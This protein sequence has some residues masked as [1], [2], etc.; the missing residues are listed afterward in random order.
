MG[1][2]APTP[3]DHQA[4][5]MAANLYVFA[6]SA[7]FGVPI[8]AFP[9]ELVHATGEAAG[10]VLAKYAGDTSPEL[11]LAMAAGSLA[12][13]AWSYDPDAAAPAPPLAPPPAPA[14][15]PKKKRAPAKRGPG[16]KFAKG[17]DA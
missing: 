6:L 2:V 16:G 17:G 15:A 13:V 12:F 4:G 9:P 11:A 14:P 10:V 3:S 5:H 8:D 7:G 1:P